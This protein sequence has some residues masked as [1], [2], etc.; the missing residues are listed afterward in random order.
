MNDE[1]EPQKSVFPPGWNADRVRRVLE[2][3]ESQR[4]DE[5]R[6]ELESAS[7]QEEPPA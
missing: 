2:C 5:V 1:P 6:E 4:E 3:Y 7:E